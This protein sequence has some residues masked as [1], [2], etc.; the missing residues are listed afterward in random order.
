M[1]MLKIMITMKLFVKRDMLDGVCVYCF[2]CFVIVMKTV[3]NELVV[4]ER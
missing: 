2:R 3:E 4:G 1:P